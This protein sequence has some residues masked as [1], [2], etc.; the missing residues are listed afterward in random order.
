MSA[1]QSITINVSDIVYELKP[2][3]ESFIAF[4]EKSTNIGTVIG[5]IT[6]TDIGDSNIT[7]FTLSDT[8]NFEI[9]TSGYITTKTILDYETTPIYNLTV[10]ATNSAG[11]SVSVSITVE[12]IVMV[13]TITRAIALEGKDL[14]HTISLSK[15]SI[16]DNFSFSISDDTAV[17]LSDYNSTA[18]FSNGVSYNEITQTIDVPSGVDSFTVKIKTIEDGRGELQ[19][20]YKLSIGNIVAT[21]II[22][23]NDVSDVALTKEQL[24][25]LLFFEKNLSLTRNTSCSTCH[26]PDYAFIDARYRDGGIDQRVFVNGA[27]SVGDDGISLGGRIAP[28]ATYAQLVPD[29]QYDGTVYK[30][31]MFWDGRATNLQAQAGGPP[32][33]HAEMMMLSKSTVVDRIKENQAYITAFENLYGSS[34]FDNSE[35]AYES[36]A[37]AISLFEK[38]EE[39]STFDSKFDRKETGEYTFSEL[40]ASGNS[41]LYG[42]HRSCNGCHPRFQEN[43]TNFEYET[44]G[45]P[46]NIVAMDAR[47]ALGQQDANATFDG[48]GGTLR[49]NGTDPDWAE[50][51]GKVRVRNFRNVAVTSPHMSNGVFQSLRTVLIFY[52]QIDTVNKEK[53]NPET[54]KPWGINDHPEVPRGKLGF[55]FSHHTNILRTVEA[56]LRTFTD[57]RYESLLPPL[58]PA[59][60]R[61]KRYLGNK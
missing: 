48:L 7:S 44:V 13:D 4:V 3:V 50:H 59:S 32:L 39:F 11:D 52:S 54:A 34:I 49:N 2:T 42:G 60:D 36:M 19:E 53:Y 17:A 29:F 22:L 37:N 40:E 55:T 10:Y 46:R 31:G 18:I 35:D 5:H 8:T 58:A 12:N 51:L 16:G 38:T 6:I 25:E 14:T 28:T 26:D 20:I 24:G 15:V 33:D 61:T 57:K 27:L 21:G 45:A 9:S 56:F 23:D 47:A 43:P 30:G 41:N 1:T